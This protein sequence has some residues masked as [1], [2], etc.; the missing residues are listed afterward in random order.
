MDTVIV[1]IDENNPDEEAI[2]KAG[3]I[4]KAG[5]LVAFPTETVYG[6]GGD[7][8]NPESSKKN[9]C[10][11][12]KTFGQSADRTYLQDRGSLCDS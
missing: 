10:W 2:K 12:G 7:A 9:I 5:G 11:P 8:L 6:L 4:I 3:E 1:S